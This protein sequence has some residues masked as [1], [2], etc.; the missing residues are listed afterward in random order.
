[1]YPSDS[2][3]D[4]LV[5]DTVARF[6]VVLHH[7]PCA[8]TPETIYLEKDDISG[9]GEAQFV[10]DNEALDNQRI[11]DCQQE[12]YKVAFPIE[13]DR[14]IN[15]GIWD[16]RWLRLKCGLDDLD[17]RYDAFKRRVILIV[18]PGSVIITAAG[19]V[20]ASANRL[21]DGNIVLINI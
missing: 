17:L 19:F 6:G 10:V 5:F 16:V 1:V 3:L 12:P 13:T 15:K 20:V 21:V 7:L 11:K 18:L 2:T 8:A 4:R 14:L 9:F